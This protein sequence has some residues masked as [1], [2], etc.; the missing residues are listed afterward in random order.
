MSYFVSYKYVLFCVLQICPIFF[1]TNMSY[2]LSY[3][4]VLLCFVQICP[5]FK[6]FIFFIVLGKEVKKE[7]QQKMSYFVSYKYVLFGV[8]QI[9]PKS[10]CSSLSKIKLL[11]RCNFNG[12]ILSILQFYKEKVSLYLLMDGLQLLLVLDSVSLLYK[13]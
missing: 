8:Q 4:Y 2:F 3:K 7:G 1:P 11:T 5:I 9:C 13:N 6:G 12:F 10:E